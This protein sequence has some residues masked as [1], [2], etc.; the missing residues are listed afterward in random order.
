M[1]A[2][3]NA[4][5]IG[6][7]IFSPAVVLIT[8]F[9]AIVF[10]NVAEVPYSARLAQG[11]A[12]AFLVASLLCAAAL[13]LALRHERLQPFAKAIL[14]VGVL[15]MAY[16]I[17]SPWTT[18]LESFAVPLA[19]ES[20]VL[21]IVAFAAWRITLPSLLSVFGLVGPLIFITGAYE[22]YVRLGSVQ[23]ARLADLQNE[24]REMPLSPTGS[25]ASLRPDFEWP[26]IE[27]AQSY[28]FALYDETLR[29]YIEDTT[30]E[31]P[32]FRLSS[33]LDPVHTYRWKFAAIKD[34]GVGEYRGWIRFDFARF[35]RARQGGEADQ[36]GAFRGNVYH[37]VFDAYQ[38][39]AF[40]FLLDEDA[41]IGRP[42]THYPNFRTSSGK[43]WSSVPEML[44]SR[45]YDPQQQLANFR[46]GVFQ[47]GLFGQMFNGGVKIHIYPHYL[48]YCFDFATTCRPNLTLKEEMLGR[49]PGERTI[50]DL[51]FLKL[52]PV[53]AKRL[54]IE[55]SAGLA[56]GVVAVSDWDYGFSIADAV[57]GS[58]AAAGESEN[59]FFSIAHFREFLAQEEFRPGSG[60]YTYLHA[61]LPHGP[62]V[63]DA[64]C[65]YTGRSD[66]VLSGYLD[67]ARCAH[68]LVRELMT[69]LESLDRL[70]NSLI[71]VQGD[72]GYFWHPKEMG[73]LLAYSPV[74]TVDFPRVDVDQ[75]DS[76]TWRSEVI[77]V[78]S[79][80]L[81][82][83][84]YPGQGEFRTADERVHI[85]DIAPTVLDFFDIP[86]DGMQGIPV[87]KLGRLAR[88]RVYFGHNK[89]PVGGE[90]AVMSRYRRI[91][92]RWV[93]E[94]DIPTL[95]P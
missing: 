41:G 13:A 31:T 67:Q 17:L 51:W 53:T 77:E 48:Y 22:H 85:I 90:P 58:S 1:N 87:P 28:K 4:K 34:G 46:L 80:A 66:D 84:K 52:L 60:Q 9:N 27:S 82:L 94:T 88:D 72:H 25:I 24:A 23:T 40:E 79:T 61:I 11:F 63:V 42:F 21:T 36:A 71:I 44:W 68:H 62:N 47:S 19:V 89:I 59:P 91:D 93:F 16:D 5:A 55:D 69:R 65:N 7:G 73:E 49:P 81:M 3:R 10:A 83:I 37:L 15:A 38:A 14:A 78:R 29:K 6:A 95:K 57:A 45:Y 43:T 8:A 26:A 20:V 86:A 12:A 70:D 92:G 32:S 39:E 18:R 30:T 35:A 64:D 75:V 74:D 56:Q 33:D 50:V 54:L 2:T 76:S